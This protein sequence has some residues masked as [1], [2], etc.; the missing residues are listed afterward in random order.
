MSDAQLEEGSLCPEC[1]V[2]SLE[3]KNPDSDSYC[4]CHV[5][6]PCNHCVSKV[7]H[8]AECNWFDLDEEY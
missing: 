1:G 7:L 2:G 5:C 3:F 6:P 8:C 4:N